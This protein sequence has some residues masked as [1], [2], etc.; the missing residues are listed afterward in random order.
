MRSSHCLGRV[1]ETNQ[2]IDKEDDFRS[3]MVLSFGNKSKAH[4][5][6]VL[7]EKNREVKTQARDIDED[8]ANSDMALK[9]FWN[10]LER[11]VEAYSRNIISNGCLWHYIN[12]VT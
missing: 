8:N 5:T 11:N 9:S 3:A 12:L 6:P 4:R 1:E 7:D 2:S 10:S